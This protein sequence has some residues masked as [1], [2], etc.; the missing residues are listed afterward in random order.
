MTE[1]TPDGTPWQCSS[2]REFMM[3]ENYYCNR[4]KGDPTPEEPMCEIAFTAFSGGQPKE[5]VYRDGKA[6]CTK[7]ELIQEA[8]Q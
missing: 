2:G 6:F 3:F 1:Q 7:F 8:A 5:W 4:C